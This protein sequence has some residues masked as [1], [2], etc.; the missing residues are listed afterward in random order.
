M[1]VHNKIDFDVILSSEKL[2]EKQKCKAI[3]PDA[4]GKELV[5]EPNTC[6][7]DSSYDTLLKM[8]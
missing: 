6:G 4:M 2:R 7:P 5:L 8:S 1:F 3:L